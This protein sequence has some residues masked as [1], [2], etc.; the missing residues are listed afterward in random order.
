V[1]QETFSEESDFLIPQNSERARKNWSRAKLLLMMRI[2][3]PKV[4]KVEVKH[5][6]PRPHMPIKWFDYCLCF[7]AIFD[8]FWSLYLLFAWHHEYIFH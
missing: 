8:L 6:G 5:S 4:I 7:V 3:L 1:V 2:R